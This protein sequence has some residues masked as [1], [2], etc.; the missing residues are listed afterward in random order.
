MPAS[1]SRRWW[2]LVAIAVSVLVVGLD[3][4]V[5]SLAL[6]TLSRELHASTGDLQ[7]FTDAYSLVIAAMVLPAGLLGDRLGR[8]KVL[9]AALLLF[10]VSSAFCAFSTSSG[11]LIAARALLGLGAA[12]I[13]PLSLSVLPVLFTPDERPKAI[14]LMASA[15]FISFPV[16]PLLGGWLLDNFWWGSV[17]LI[18]VP[19]VAL[20]LVTVAF[21]MPE[22]RSRQRPRLD[23][24]GVLISGLGLTALTYGFIKAGEDGWSDTAS[25][26]TIVAGVAVLGLFVAWERRVHGRG[27]QPLVDLSLFRSASFTWGTLLS[28]LVTFALF[29]I[30]FAMPLYFQDVRG[31]DALGSGL[32]LLPMIGGM[33]VGMIGG[34]R[35][36]SPRRGPDGEPTD[37]IVSVKALVTAGYVVMAA[38]LAIGTLTHV[39]TGTGFTAA[40]FAV[41]G[42]GLGLAMPAAMNAAISPLTAD[43]SASGT[44]LITAMRQ[45]GGT[46]GVAVLG[47]VISDAYRS[48]LHLSGLPAGAASAVRSSIGEAVQVAHAAH[49]TALLGSVRG[50]Y[51]HGLDIMLWVCAAIALACALLALAF[52]PRRLTGAVQPADSG[53]VAAPAG[54]RQAQ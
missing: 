21:L 37:S 11:E 10:G 14:A 4:T 30:L 26:A 48:G 29:G 42:L 31:V 51:T 17:F 46:I 38:G 20:A 53:D 22:S 41:A 33:V 49:A 52:L 34:S 50:A 18:N 9:L 39:G 45:V 32:R 3:L 7:W 19:I 40:W 16:G 35:L 2:A 25:L 23:V 12:A 15:T 27:G 44:A 36:Q 24:P 54:A 8:K 6:P 1:D 13:M 28:T 43:R 47:T 5:L